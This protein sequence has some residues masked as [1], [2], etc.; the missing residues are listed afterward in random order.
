MKNTKK[1][2]FLAIF[3]I[4][5]AIIF[6]C[7]S[8]GGTKAGAEQDTP[9]LVT[10]DWF[11]YDDAEPPNNGSSTVKFTVEKEIIDGKEEMVT[12]VSGNVTTKYQYGFSGWGITA[13]EKIF[14]LYKTAKS[15]SFW[16]LGDGQRYTIK[17]VIS[18]VKDYGDYEYTFTTEK[19]VPKKIE[20]PMK[21]FMQ[22]SWAKPVKMDQTLVTQVQWQTHESWRKTGNNNPFDI[23]MW[24]FTVYN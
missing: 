17:Y 22:P 8:S 7:A 5:C 9:T 16:I 21:Y 20:V 19:G 10:G 15:F 24:G 4:F 12:H 13:D 11:I 6:S 1:L 18:S 14:E 2:C 3:V 23:K